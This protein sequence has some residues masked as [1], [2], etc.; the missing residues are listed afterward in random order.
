VRFREGTEVRTIVIDGGPPSFKTGLL[1][2]LTDSDVTTVDLMVATHI[3]HNHVAGL[4]PVAASDAITIRNFWGP[5]CESSQATVKGLRNGDERLYQ[6]LYAQVARKVE[7]KSILCPTR[8]ARVPELFTGAN[9]T[10]LNPRTPNV[11]APELE[12]APKPK[13]GELAVEQNDRSIVLHFESHGMRVLFTS[14]AERRFW[15]QAS[16]REDILHYLDVHVLKA[17]HYGRLGGFPHT[18]AA[19]VDRL[20]A[21]VFSIGEELDRQPQD[22]VVR[23]VQ[24]RG[25]QVF[26][27]QHAPSTSFCVNP[28]CCAK[29][30][31][32]NVLFFAYP[33]CRSFAPSAEACAVGH[34]A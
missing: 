16:E 30:G 25:G 4:L 34:K 7:A 18:V 32:Q 22:E 29:Q 24:E 11:L 27:T 5:V 28:S 20:G 15:I 10:V 31:G 9:L 14:D 33:G 26:C 8:G 6:R 1:D 23:L 3:D 17:A 2:Y 19:E 21:V 13:P 12:G